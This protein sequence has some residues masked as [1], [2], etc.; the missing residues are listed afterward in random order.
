MFTLTSKPWTEQAACVGE[1]PEIFFSDQ[2]APSHE[3]KR[4]CA[5]CPARAT[6][7]QAALDEDEEF[8]IWAGLGPTERRRIKR[9]TA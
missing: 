6:C 7:H 2:G 4:I 3:A 1:D 5:R 9:A 8:G